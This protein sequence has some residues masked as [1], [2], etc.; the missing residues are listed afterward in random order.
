MERVLAGAIRQGAAVIANLRAAAIADMEVFRR[1]SRWLASAVE[2]TLRL[3]RTAEA[4]TS[5]SLV[6]AAVSL[7]DLVPVA[8]PGMGN[9]TGSGNGRQRH[10]RA[11]R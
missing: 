3:D 5:K 7:D 9:T 2:L 8:P 1:T 11:T 4:I 6:K 10:R